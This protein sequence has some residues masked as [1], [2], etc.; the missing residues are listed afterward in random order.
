MTQESVLAGYAAAKEAA[1]QMQGQ[2]RAP[3]LVYADQEL[4][5]EKKRGNRVQY[6]VST[7]PLGYSSK[8]SDEQVC[9]GVFCS[10]KPAWFYLKQAPAPLQ[11]CPNNMAAKS[12]LLI[13]STLL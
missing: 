5:F 7:T 1:A 3:F 9:V 11:A 12:R 4:K 8:P 6:E 10:A 2:Q 13:A